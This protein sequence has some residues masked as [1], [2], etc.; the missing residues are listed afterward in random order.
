[1]K[2]ERRLE[3][4][5]SLH[6]LKPPADQVPASTGH[7][8]RRSSSSFDLES[9]KNIDPGSLWRNMVTGRGKD[10]L[11]D[12]EQRITPWQDDSL[13]NRC[14]LCNASFHPITNRKHHCRLCGKIICALPPKRPHRP[15]S[16][17]LLFVVDPQ[18]KTIEEVGEGVDYGVKRRRGVSEGDLASDDDKFLKGVRICRGCRPILL[19]KKY[20]EESSSMPSFVHLHNVLVDL[21]QE[22]EGA[23]PQF[24]DLILRL[25]LNDPPTREASA[26]RKR[27]LEAFA[28]YDALSKRIYQ[29]PRPDGSENS[30]FRVQAAVLSRAS[31]FLQKNMIPLKSLPTAMSLASPTS[32]SIQNG[33]ITPPLLDLELAHK[34]Q[35]LLEQEALLETFIEEAESHRKF[36]DVKTLKLNL[37]EIKAEIQKIADCAMPPSKERIR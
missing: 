15:L 36:E 3:K 10:G 1:M 14:P 12:A 34:L 18:S 8:T 17:S 24:Q 9:I 20:R 30:Q 22:I 23:L 37:S 19:C 16:C 25:S 28:Q 2:L 7:H 13:V 11:R 21:E 35:P 27:L 32:P 4:L 26:L 29:L 6:F 31:I 5:I 33:T